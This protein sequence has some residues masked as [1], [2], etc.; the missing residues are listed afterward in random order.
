MNARLKIDPRALAGF[1]LDRDLEERILEK[2]GLAG[3]PKPDLS[4]LTTLYAA[5]CQKVPFDSIRKRIFLAEGAAHPLPDI[6]PEDYFRHWLEHGTGGTCWPTCEAWW[7]L[8]R[9]L[10]FEARRVAGAMLDFPQIA[11]PNH[12]TIAVD[13][14]GASYLVDS[15]WRTEVPLLLDHR[16]TRAGRLPSID[17]KADGEG[18]GRVIHWRFHLGRDWMRFGE[19]EDYQDVT[20]AF[21]C[22]RYALTGGDNSAFNHWT[23]IALNRGDDVHSI[24]KRT[25]FVLHPDDSIDAT[26]LATKADRDAVLVEQFGISAEMAEQLP[27]CAP[28]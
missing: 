27:D 5:W 22:E 14:S 9:S 15:F 11:A 20:N 6:T 16:P 21:Y 19:D 23:Y 8:L 3:A 1:T 17:V 12:A 4:G 18:P 13:I 7:T 10:G 28:V 24:Y 26:P 25:H 2:L